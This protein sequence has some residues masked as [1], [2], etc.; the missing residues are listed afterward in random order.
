MSSRAA[1][2][3]LACSLLLASR[4]DAQWISG[5]S[6]GLA[7]PIQTITFGEIALTD[8]TPVFDQWSSF[9][10]L[11][12]GSLFAGNPPAFGGSPFPTTALY[13][14]SLQ[15]ALCCTSMFAMFFTSVL[16]GAAFNFFSQPTSTTFQA[17]LSGQLVSSFTAPTGPVAGSWYGFENVAFDQ[18][19][20][21]LASSVPAGLDNLHTTDVPTAVVPE[22]STVIL[23]GSGLALVGLA[24]VRRRRRQTRSAAK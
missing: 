15:P 14:F 22:P 4:G 9:G 3:V 20:V 21:T 11:V 7:N 13:N 8:N 12:S 2:V 18:V 10:V 24:Q 6:T 19:Q 16:H 5:R 17:F 23:V 1:G